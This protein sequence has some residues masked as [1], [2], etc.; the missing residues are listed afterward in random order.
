MTRFLIHF[1]LSQLTALNAG[2][3]FGLSTHPDYSLA[4][5][6]TLLLGAVAA[7][8]VAAWL[9]LQGMEK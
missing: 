9:L 1:L 2:I 3:L 4:H 5:G 6:I 8:I 7:L